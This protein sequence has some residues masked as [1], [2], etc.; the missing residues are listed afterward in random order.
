MDKYLELSSKYDTFIYE[1]YKIEEEYNKTII[2]YDFNVPNLTHYYPKLELKKFKITE[3]TKYLIFHVGL[4]E[5]ISYWKAT[6][7]KN[8]IIKA[9]Y[10]NKEQINFFKKL[11]FHGLGE[12]FYTNNIEV[13]FDNFM[14]IT[15]VDR[16]SVV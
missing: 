10:I 14:K 3:Y 2:T 1:G 13:D 7:S 11:Y 12:L 5:L 4:V 6:C 9:G 16:K 15:C 8:V